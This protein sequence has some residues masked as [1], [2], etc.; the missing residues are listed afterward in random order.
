AYDAKE[1]KILSEYPARQY[2][3]LGYDQMYNLSAGGG[4]DKVTYYSAVH[5]ENLK[6]SLPT[7]GKH[8]Y[9]FRSNLTL[10]RINKLTVRFGLNLRGNHLKAPYP[11]WGLMGEFVLADPREKSAKRPFGELYQTIPGALA[12]NNT[13]DDFDRTING[14]IKYEFTKAISAN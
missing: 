3:K 10:T 2:F 9:G 8:N 1:N 14:H 13:D 4:N 5:Y 7:N 12:Y 11:S 6:G